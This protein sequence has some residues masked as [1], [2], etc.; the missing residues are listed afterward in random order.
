MPT[1][2]VHAR[3]TLIVAESVSEI[4]SA[5]EAGDTFYATNC[6]GGGRRAI[7]PKRVTEVEDAPDAQ[8]EGPKT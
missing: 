1:R 3:D 4:K 7:H 6:D 2:I 8:C 5:V